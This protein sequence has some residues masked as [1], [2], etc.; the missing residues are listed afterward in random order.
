MLSLVTALGAAAQAPCD[1]LRYLWWADDD[2]GAI[3]RAP[4]SNPRA[5]TE[6]VSG[7]TDPSG[8]HVDID[9]GKVYWTDQTDDTISRANLDGSNVEI[10]ISTGLLRARD[11]TMDPLAGKLYWSDIDASRIERSNLDGTGR[12][13]IITG[14][15]PMGIELDLDAGAMYWVDASSRGLYRANLDGSSLEILASGL[16]S[17]WDV[18]LD[19]ESDHLYWSDNTDGEIWRA[20]LDGSDATLLVSGLTE[21]Q[22]LILDLPGGRMYWTT[23]AGDGGRILRTTLSGQQLSSWTPYSVQP[24]DVSLDAQGTSPCHICFE[25]LVEPSDPGWFGRASVDVQFDYYD[26]RFVMLVGAPL[27]DSLAPAGGA[28]YLYRWNGASWD[29]EQTLFPSDPGPDKQ[30]GYRV[31]MSPPLAL[32]ANQPWGDDDAVYV[33]HSDGE[34][35][36]EYDRLAPVSPSTEAWGYGMDVVE[37]GFLAIG[38]AKGNDSYVEMFDYAGAEGIVPLITITPTRG[39]DVLSLS[40]F[41]ESLAIGRAGAPVSEIRDMI[42]VSD[43]AAPLASGDFGVTYVFE[44]DALSSSFEQVQEILPPQSP[45]QCFGDDVVLASDSVTGDRLF[46]SASTSAAG[47]GRCHVYRHDGTGWVHASTVSAWDSDGS[48]FDWFGWEMDARGDVLVAGAANADAA[49]VYQFDGLDWLPVDKLRD[50][51]GID[52]FGWAVSMRFDM[53]SLGHVGNDERV[54]SYRLSSDPCPLSA[55]SP[56]QPADRVEHMLG[57]SPS[58]FRRATVVTFQLLRPALAHVSVY[59]ARGRMLRRLVPHAMLAAGVH[60]LGWDGRDDH[61]RE[62]PSGVYFVQLSHGSS[63]ITQRLVLTR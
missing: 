54:V 31:V 16:T 56:E 50:P 40:G 59:D 62:V 57:V 42:V 20:S 30:F 9:G 46:I 61:G 52:Q 47:P 3:V 14:R 45:A 13:T 37:E 21:P 63:S 33:F 4:L 49:Y 2:L 51:A 17:P 60:R 5:P 35:W 19:V 11:I 44:Y 29:L 34:T 12:E 39:P 38:S 23:G 32:I 43:W 15:D 48:S 6:I 1:A 10:V 58:P 22:F 7:L 25:E 8:I 28:A 36:T 53:L 55:G 24:I 41:G 27:D 26:D 18:A